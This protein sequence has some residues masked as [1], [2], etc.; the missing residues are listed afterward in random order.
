M[1]KYLAISHDKCAAIGF[2]EPKKHET[3]SGYIIRLLLKGF[4]VTTRDCRFIEIANLHS[5]IPVLK[6]K[7]YKFSHEHKQAY[8]HTSKTTPPQMVDVIFMD[9]NQRKLAMSIKYTPK[10]KKPSVN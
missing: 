1:N 4:V 6:K 5:V 8:C 7:G 9:A 2:L 3:Q 10:T